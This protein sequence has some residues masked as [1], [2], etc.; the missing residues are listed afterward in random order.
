LRDSFL[1][2]QE[3][4]ETYLA[5]IDYTAY[6]IMFSNWVQ[7]LM[8]LGRIVSRAEFQHYQQNASHF[9]SSLENVSDNVSFV[10]I[11]VD[12]SD[13]G[14]DGGSAIPM[15]WSNNTFRYNSQYRVEKQ[16]WFEQLC[17]EHKY[18]EY[19]HS[20][21]FAAQGDAWSMTLYYLMT[22]YYNFS[23]IGYLAIN[24]TAE[25]L[26][27][28][29]ADN[30]RREYI[31]VSDRAE[32]VI[33]A[34]E[35]DAAPHDYLS[36]AASILDENAVMRIFRHA[37]LNPFAGLGTYNLF[38]LLLIPIMAIFALITMLFSRYLSAPIV[39]CRGAML[40][41]RHNR[42]GILLENH[43]HDEIGDL[44]G[45]FNE[46]SRALHTLLEQNHN[47]D[48]L[49]REAELEI[50]QQKVN[51]HFLYNT[52]EIINALI[53]DEQTDEAMRVCEMLGQMYHYNLMNRKWVKLRE[54]VDYVQQYLALL[55]HKMS[56]LSVVWELDEAALDTNTLRLIVQPLVE[57]AVLHGLRTKTDACL[58]III[59]KG[60]EEI[61]V[62]IMDNGAG[63]PAAT[64]ADIER[65]LA[66]LRDNMR[67][68]GP[69][70]G[71]RNVYQRLYL[72]YGEHLHFVID[73]HEGYGARFTFTIPL[74]VGSV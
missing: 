16:P 27:F 25:K 24:V 48:R 5:R 65:T 34:T 41:I 63:I 60:A 59:H 69:H 74:H 61:S 55:R 50:L 70:I 36:Y 4:L 21:L 68:E 3:R 56:N 44:I 38:F 30:A 28:L 26:R 64:L 54:E 22:N 23:P 8:T 6:T 72:E 1:R 19:G 57:N 45:G 51:P 73:S 39:K 20:E 35:T 58:S 29:V 43:Y 37:P 49:R 66:K 67:I 40:E 12:N 10:L 42:F 53:L 17:R 32:R 52:L 7:Q 2:R 13:S 33:C 71:I 62:T 15:L 14:G 46:M 18:I 31:M 9:L 11:S 47:I